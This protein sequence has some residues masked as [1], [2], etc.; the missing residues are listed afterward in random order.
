[1]FQ[2]ILKIMGFFFQKCVIQFLQFVFFFFFLYLVYKFLLFLSGLLKFVV[3]FIWD[4]CFSK[5]HV[6]SFIS[7]R[8]LYHHNICI[9]FSVSFNAMVCNLYYMSWEIKIKG[10]KICYV[11]KFEHIHRQIQ[12]LNKYFEICQ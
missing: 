5:K 9:S 7:R 6:C 2:H 8:M 12:T 10:L 11:M 3:K 4:V 1:M